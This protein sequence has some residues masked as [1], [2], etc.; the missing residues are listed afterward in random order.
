M[1]C[2]IS[3]TGGRLLAE[4]SAILKKDT[5]VIILSLEDEKEY[6]LCPQLCVDA[7]LRQRIFELENSLRVYG[8]DHPTF[9]DY[10]S[11]LE[12]LD[13]ERLFTQ[14]QIMSG[15]LSV[16][17][18]Y[19]DGADPILTD[20]CSSLCGINHTNAFGVGDFFKLPPQVFSRKFNALS[21]LVEK[22][23]DVCDVEQYSIPPGSELK[24]VTL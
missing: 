2:V 9:L 5:H 16:V 10:P 21:F 18:L 12:D 8:I 14:L 23:L 6:R 15:L 3:T 17:T 1:N 4:A 19:Y 7:T 11:V 24:P 13:R 22:E 20:V